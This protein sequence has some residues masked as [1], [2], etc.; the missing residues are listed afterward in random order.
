[1]LKHV[2]HFH[3]NKFSFLFFCFLRMVSM[4]ETSRRLKSG[5]NKAPLIHGKFGAFGIQ[6]GMNPVVVKKV[7]EALFHL[8]V[9]GLHFNRV[10]NAKRICCF[11]NFDIGSIFLTV[12]I[13]EGDGGSMVGKTTNI[14]QFFIPNRVAKDGNHLSIQIQ[15]KAN[16]RCFEKFLG[17]FLV[18]FLTIF[19]GIY[20]L[21][22]VIFD[23]VGYFFYL[24]NFLDT[25]DSI[26]ENRIKLKCQSGL[27]ST[28]D[29]SETQI[30]AP[31]S[32]KCSRKNRM[33]K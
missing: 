1:M 16:I 33:R 14:F 10:S 18:Q 12:N 7:R 3:S 30:P 15:K 24:F 32:T 4:R 6:K 19:P 8:G 26:G 23:N 21:R 5:K 2:M 28:Q 20:E 29:C 17:D 11:V 25:H 27:V 31:F 9:F 22:T 13:T